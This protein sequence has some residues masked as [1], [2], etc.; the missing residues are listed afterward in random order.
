MLGGPLEGVVQHL[1]RLA[2]REESTR[3]DDVQLLDRF[4][5]HR[6]QAAFET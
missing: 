2:G 3:A 5:K 6:D 4:L 1:R